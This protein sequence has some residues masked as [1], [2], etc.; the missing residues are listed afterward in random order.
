MNEL[1]IF[2]MLS[3]EYDLIE[4][5]RSLTEEEWNNWFLSGIPTSTGQIA[6]AYKVLDGEVKRLQETKRRASRK[7][8]AV[9]KLQ[10]N[11]KVQ[12]D[13]RLRAL[14]ED[15]NEK[16]KIKD[17]GYTVS[18]QARNTRVYEDTEIPEGFWIFEPKIDKAK[19]DLSI[20]SGLK[21]PGVTDCIVRSVVVRESP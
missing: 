6:Q 9:C 18:Y 10:D 3:E 7:L 2:S 1:K 12:L 16:P 14:F 4:S 19:I 5:E 21:V 13:G 20:E 15:G 17:L 11:L 8:E